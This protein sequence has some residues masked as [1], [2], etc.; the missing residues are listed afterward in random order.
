MLPYFLKIL[1]CISQLE[2]AQLFGVHTIKS[3]MNS[4]LFSSERSLTNRFDFNEWFSFLFLS[5][6]IEQTSSTNSR[7]TPRDQFTEYDRLSR[8]SFFWFSSTGRRRHWWAI[9]SSDEIHQQ[10][11]F[12]FQSALS[13]VCV[14]F[15]PM[16]FIV[17]HRECLVY[18]RSLKSLII[19][20]DEFDFNGLEF[21]KLLANISIEFVFFQRSREQQI[22]WRV[23]LGRF[24]FVTRSFVLRHRFT[25]TIVDEISWKRRIR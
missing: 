18:R 17:N 23:H 4:S 15:L 13:I 20:W 24:A 8:S 3:K 22:S 11:F 21:G 25:S 12:L 6:S 16:N 9:L 14:E 1:K 5:S 7:S 2:L 19:T 10:I